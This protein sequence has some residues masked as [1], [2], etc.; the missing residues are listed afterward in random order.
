MPEENVLAF[1]SKIA[2]IRVGV[3]INYSVAFRPNVL[4]VVKTHKNNQ[5]GQN[6]QQI[7]FNC[8]HPG[9]WE[10]KDS[11]LSVFPQMCLFYGLGWWCAG[12]QCWRQTGVFRTKWRFFQ[13]TFCFNRSNKQ[14][15]TPWCWDKA[16]AGHFSCTS[17]WHFYRWTAMDKVK[18]I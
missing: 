18:N 4:M 13:G 15:Q 17:L 6:P 7:Y 9:L 5:A 1:L 11:K 8:N 16:K 12:V 2:Q 3:V 10:P 14:K